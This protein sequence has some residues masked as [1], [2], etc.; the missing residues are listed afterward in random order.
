M[1]QQNVF[2]MMHSNTRKSQWSSGS[3]YYCDQK[4]SRS[5]SHCRQLSVCVYHDMHHSNCK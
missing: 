5:E 1:R 3:T 2:T 4:N